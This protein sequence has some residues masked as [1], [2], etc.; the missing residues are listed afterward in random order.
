M[1][2]SLLFQDS[3]FLPFCKSKMLYLLHATAL[4]Q[5]YN[6]F[7]FFNFFLLSFINLRV[8]YGC[9]M[10]SK[11]FVAMEKLL[12]KEIFLYFLDNDMDLWVEF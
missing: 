12:L 10:L 5:L 7:C 2:V 4:M 8:P 9:K 1:D 11:L 6:P 3:C